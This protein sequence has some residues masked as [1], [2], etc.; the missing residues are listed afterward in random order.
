[1][2]LVSIAA[3]HSASIFGRFLSLTGAFSDVIEPSVPGLL[4]EM[5]E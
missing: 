5:E 2:R 1:M 3:K 4:S